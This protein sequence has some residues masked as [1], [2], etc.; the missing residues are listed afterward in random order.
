M[1]MRALWVNLVAVVVAGAVVSG[2]A[3]Q[4]LPDTTIWSKV[5]ATK[6]K[7][8]DSRGIAISAKSKITTEPGVEPPIITGVDIW[9]GKGLVWAGGNYATC[10]KRM[11]D[12]KG[13]SGCPKRSIMGSATATAWAD[14][15]V[16]HPDVVLVNGGQKRVFAYTT[17]YRPSLV[18]ETI[19][20]RETKASG[21]WAHKESFRVPENLQIVAGVP[22]RVT[23]LSLK[24]GGKPYAP[25]FI[26]SKFCPAGGWRYKA[27]AHL[28]YDLLA[29]TDQETVTGTIPC[30][31]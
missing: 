25:E 6:V 1:R 30:P 15:V 3:A 5:R 14:T 19:V 18:K 22:I 2:A 29:V 21:P 10:S 17:L 24:V 4:D 13:P 9:I 27:T 28:L 20:V 16:T 23:A 8:G 26:S 31:K 11:L 12:R 7:G